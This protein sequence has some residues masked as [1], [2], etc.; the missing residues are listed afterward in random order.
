MFKQLIQNLN[1]A[2]K[3][4]E[5]VQKDIDIL[6]DGGEIKRSYGLQPMTRLRKDMKE[7]KE[8]QENPE[9]TKIVD[10]VNDIIKGAFK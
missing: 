2:S 6:K 3:E 1:T 5:K 8:E 7:V 4:L 10:K 9:M